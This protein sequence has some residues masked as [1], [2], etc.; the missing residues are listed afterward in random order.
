MFLAIPLESRPSWRSPPWMT[1]A[2]ILLNVLVFFGW[3][4]P[5]DKAVER[6]AGRYAQTDLPAIELPAFVQHLQAQAKGQAGEQA[7]EARLRARAA[8]Q[9]LDERQYPLLYQLMWHDSAFRQRLLDGRV[10]GPGHPQHAQ[11][12]AARASFTPSE[13]QPFTARWAQN[14]ASDAPWRPVTWLTN[15]FLHGST[16][17]LL[18]NMVFLFL[19]GF[20]LE[21]AL[22]AGPYLLLYLLGGAGASALAAWAYAGHGGLGLGASGAVAALMGMYAVLYRFRRI[23][24]FYMLFFYFNYARW[25]ALVMLPVWA[26]HELVQHFIG[27]SHVAYMAHLG[28]LLT[29]ALLM[30]VMVAAGRVQAPQ[31]GARAQAASQSAGGQDAEARQA[32]LQALKAKARQHAHGL[33]FAEAARVWQ[34]AARLAPRDA[35]VLQHWFECA[36]HEPASDGFHA[37]AHAIFKLPAQ[38]AATRQ[39]QADSYRSYLQTARPGMRLSASAMQALVRSLAAQQQWN[40]AQHLARALSR[41]SPP[42]E[43]WP[44][45]LGMLVSALLKDGQHDAARAWLPTL[46]RDAPDEPVTQWLA[47]QADKA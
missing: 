45:T 42:P 1:V 11:W 14:H 36:R 27:A 2:L 13:P 20:T 43:G 22:G 17:H 16:G 29:G 32:R 23:P 33:R 35:K 7:D 46:M 26:G 47:R 28:G 37:A 34:Q 6:A 5:E 39:L 38:D 9:A 3:Q 15:T 40:D 4:A 30:A 21:M 12:Q 10:I 25:P 24:F 41:M 8:A 31:A 18:G 19:F 44:A